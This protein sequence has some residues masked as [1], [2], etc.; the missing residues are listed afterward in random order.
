MALEKCTKLKIKNV[1]ALID[2][3]EDE[4]N[5]YLVTE[6]PGSG[7]LND[8]QVWSTKLITERETKKLMY[9]IVRALSD[10]HLC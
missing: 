1:V 6:H 7:S 5:F 2:A 8:L 10:L 9:M 4:N 3:F